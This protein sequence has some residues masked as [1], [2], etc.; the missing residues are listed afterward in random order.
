MAIGTF[1]KLLLDGAVALGMSQGPDSTALEQSA[2]EKAKDTTAVA[3]AI[4][5]NEG[6]STARNRGGKAGK[7]E[8]PE[9]P[10]PMEKRQ[11]EAYYFPDNS[12]FMDGAGQ[13]WRVFN[14]NSIGFS[15]NRSSIWNAADKTT[16]TMFDFNYAEGLAKNTAI[17]FAIDHTN[18]TS[19]TDYTLRQINA[20]IGLGIFGKKD[21]A[22]VTARLGL[23]SKPHWSEGTM[24]FNAADVTGVY[25]MN[26]GKGQFVYSVRLSSDEARLKGIGFTTSLTDKGSAGT[27]LIVFGTKKQEFTV[28][29]ALENE[30]GA[31]F[32]SG[33]SGKF[34][35]AGMMGNIQRRDYNYEFFL[36]KRFGEGSKITGRLGRDMSNC[37]N[38]ATYGRVGLDL[39]FKDIINFSKVAKNPKQGAQ[40]KPQKMPY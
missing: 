1:G 38:N 28:G 2:Y 15:H 40:Y 11:E 3:S 7:G 37:G 10:T 26:T 17:G 27:V 14:K 6:Y 33:V 31:G 8:A 16:Y 23:A 32:N 4:G 39:S 18:T 36:S 12:I 34:C 30:L 19:E 25:V 22:Y 9:M 5:G 24:Q 20:M 35:M 29:G 21:A 13:V